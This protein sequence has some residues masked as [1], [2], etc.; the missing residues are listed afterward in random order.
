MKN[1]R[2]VL[3]LHLM[4]EKSNVL[5]EKN[6]S[7]VFKVA[8]EANKLDVKKAVEKVFGVKV[9]SVRTMIVPDKPKRQGRFEGRSTAWK[10]AV[11]KLK[12][13]QQIG[14]FENV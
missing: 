10:K 3:Q 5:K 8:R 14:V 12:K 6:N 2:R 4:T 13:G 11:V 1:D 9:E 7:Y